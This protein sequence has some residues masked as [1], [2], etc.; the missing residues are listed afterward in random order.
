MP[1]LSDFDAFVVR[2]R[3]HLDLNEHGL[4]LADYNEAAR[5]RP[6]AEFLKMLGEMSTVGGHRRFYEP[7][8][9]EATIT[10]PEGY[11]LPN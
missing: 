7:A 8:R 6:D 1:E 2:A 10:S 5:L 3:A 11:I 9:S 4:A